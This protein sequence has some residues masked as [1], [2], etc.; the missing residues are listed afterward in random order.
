MQKKAIRI[1]NKSKYNS[2]TPMLFASLKILP[3]E[4]LITLTAGQLIH[5]IYYKYSPESLHDTWIT[6]EQ[7]GINQDLRDSHQLYTPFARTDHV[8]RLPYFSFPKLWNEL[9]DFKLSRN[10]ITFKIALKW[11]LHNLAP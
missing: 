4:H 7:R 3:L 11:H 10:P 6:N 8:K 5:S 1:I 9:P 2:P